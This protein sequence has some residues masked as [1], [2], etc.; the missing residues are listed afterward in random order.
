M[1]RSDIDCMVAELPDGKLIGHSAL[2][3]YPDR[4]RAIE[5]VIAVI[6]PA[7]RG[8]GIM[9]KLQLLTNDAFARSGKIVRFGG[10]VTAH[11]VSQKAS[12]HNGNN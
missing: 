10:A 5:T 11:A 12:I 8:Q 2:I 7:H 6:Y 4:P 1:A 3:H 9:A